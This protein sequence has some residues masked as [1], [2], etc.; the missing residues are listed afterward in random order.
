[1]DSKS[2]SNQRYHSK[3]LY[4]TDHVN[5]SYQMDHIKANESSQGSNSHEKSLLKRDRIYVPYA[6]Q[7]P[8]HR[9]QTETETTPS[10]TDLH[11]LIT[12]YYL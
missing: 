3:G 12:K 6:K 10:S 9:K 5:E 7:T 4:Q 11:E 1:M 8:N 2:E